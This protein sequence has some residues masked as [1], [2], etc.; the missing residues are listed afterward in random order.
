MPGS[1]VAT[2]QSTPVEVGGLS[3]VVAVAGGGLHSLAVKGDGTVWAWGQNASGQLGDGTTT[4]RATPLQVSGL[5]GVVAVAAG[6]ENFQRAHS[7]AVKSDGTVWAWGWNASGQLG[8]GTTA[9]RSTP[10]QVSGITGVMAVA[11]GQSHSLALKGDG[12]VWEW[13]RQLVDGRERPR[14][15]PVQVSGLTGVVA[16]TEGSRP[17][18]AL[19]GDGTVW[20]WAWDRPTPVQVS[21]LSGVVAVAGGG[22]HSLALKGDG[23]LWAWG[24][25]YS[26]QLG[27]GTDTPRA[28]PVQ[29]SG[30][31]EVVAVAAGGVHSLA[32]KRDGTLWAWGANYSGQLG[33]GTIIYRSTPVPLSGPTGVAAVAVGGELS[34]ALKGDGTLRQWTWNQSTPVSLSG[35]TGVVAIT[36][37]YS[38][39]LALKG[40]G[41]VWAW[42]RNETGQLGDGTVTDRTTPVQVSGLSGVVGVAAGYA[43]SL[44]LK[45]DGTVWAWGGNWGG[46]LG[47]G[48]NMN[49]SAPVHVSGLTGVVGVAAGYTHSLAAKGDGTVWAWGGNDLG[50]LGDGTSTHYRSTPVQ[51]SGLSGVVA[52]AGGHEYSLAVKGDGTV[53]AWGWNVYGQLGDGTTALWRTTPVQVSGLSGVVTVAAGWAEIP[54][55]TAGYSLAVKADGTVWAWGW[56]VHGQ[57]GDGTTTSRTTPVQVAGL[58][59]VKAVAG[60]GGYSVAVK[61]DGTLWAW[62]WDSSGLLGGGTTT[63]QPTPVQVVPLGSPVWAGTVVVSA[64]VNAASFRAGPIAPG[65]IVTIFGKDMGPP[66]GLSGR[67]NAAG[68]FESTLGQTRVLFDGVAAPIL[69]ARADQVTAVA[70]YPLAGKRTTEVQV[71]YRGVKSSPQ[72]LTVAES[73]P[74]IFSMGAT[75]SGQGVILNEEG[76]LNSASKPARRGSMVTLFATGEGQTSPPGVDGKVAAG[77]MPRPVLRVSVLIGGQEAPV[78]DA[79]CAPGL[80]GVLQVR[81]WVPGPIAPGPAVPV[82]LVVGEARSQAGVTMAVQ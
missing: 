3:G 21:G 79:G 51:V 57:L 11:A 16:V 36:A 48:T 45:G 65:E 9:D 5:S 32:L 31:S 28:T 38:H 58:S 73:A 50:Q 68:L 30:L 64:V 24:A 62:G 43:H 70:P 19:K 25:N 20:E 52:V 75:G 55:T 66:A 12:T 42:G 18:L 2:P 37:G 27:D 69:F 67:P 33:D 76:S 49:R 8:D 41:S 81:A 35:L 29:V 13:G 44:A 15:T 10:V 77:P 39:V 74:G 34:L 78:Y 40:D 1:G 82:T 14:S 54:F 59:G 6:W 17:S 53:W 71:E 7:L 72:T 80:A 26:G 46:Q 63:Y 60:G 56:N 23:T 22:G 4:D 61:R 47:D